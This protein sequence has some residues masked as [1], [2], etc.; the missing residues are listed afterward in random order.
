MSELR[1]EA[2]WDAARTGSVEWA[3]NEAVKAVQAGRGPES[4]KDHGLPRKAK[5]QILRDIDRKLT[6]YGHQWPEEYTGRAYGRYAPVWQWLDGRSSEGEPW[7]PGDDWFIS[8]LTDLGT[9]E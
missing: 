9:F 2:G 5:K 3:W 6:R 7:Y 8:L 1:S 4:G